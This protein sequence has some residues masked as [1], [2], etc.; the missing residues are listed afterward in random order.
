MLDLAFGVATDV[1]TVTQDDFEARWKTFRRKIR[2]R[3]RELSEEGHTVRGFYVFP[4][5]RDGLRHVLRRVHVLLENEKPIEFYLA[6]RTRS[7]KS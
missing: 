3:T 5:Q 4:E 2:D 1:A 6:V 7:S